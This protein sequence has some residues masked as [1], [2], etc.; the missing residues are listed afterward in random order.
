MKT[1]V[2]VRTVALSRAIQLL[3]SIGCRYKV[4]TADGAEYGVLEAVEPKNRKAPSRYPHGAVRDYIRTIVG[5]MNVGDVAH[6]PVA[7]FDLETLQNG[8][9]SF[10]AQQ[11]GAGSAITRLDRAAARIEILRVT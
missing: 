6:I 1:S 5:S 11:W 10:A 4:I 9:C 2:D 3:D 7:E 8:A